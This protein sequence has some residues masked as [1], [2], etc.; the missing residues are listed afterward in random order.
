[1]GPACAASPSI[2]RPPCHVA[3][4][5]CRIHVHVNPTLLSRSFKEYR[6]LPALCPARCDNGCPVVLMRLAGTCAF[7]NR[8]E[9]NYPNHGVAITTTICAESNNLAQFHYTLP[10]CTVYCKPRYPARVHASTKL[11]SLAANFGAPHATSFALLLTPT[12]KSSCVSSHG[13]GVG[14]RRRRR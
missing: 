5:S 11:V 3:A 8:F 6:I 13:T 4:Y 1:M 10:K 9:D 12:S 7:D 14:R 2:Q